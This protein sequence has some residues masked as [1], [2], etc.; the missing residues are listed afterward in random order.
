MMQEETRKVQKRFIYSIIVMCVLMG[1]H[2]RRTNVSL[3]YFQKS[4]RPKNSMGNGFAVKYNASNP[5]EFGNMELR[6]TFV[7]DSKSKKSSSRTPKVLIAQ[8]DF[9]N[10]NNSYAEIIS[11]TSKVNKAYAHKYEHDYLLARGVFI[12]VGDHPEFAKGKVAAGSTSN[13]VGI[14]EY[15]MQHPDKD[16]DYVLIMDSDA[17]MYDFER[18]IALIYNMTHESLIAHRVL[19]A[20]GIKSFNINAGVILWNI[21]HQQTQQI[22]NLWDDEIHKV[23]RKKV[24]EDQEALHKVLHRIPAKFRPVR[25]IRGDFEYSEGTVVKHFI[26]P[27]GKQVRRKWDDSKLSTSSRVMHIR[28]TAEEIC[29]KYEKDC[30]GVTAE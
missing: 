14:L 9:G 2:I 21:K 15:A 28:N 29:K 27:G 22:V 13:K 1:A 8:Y 17:M 12:E 16:W 7:D 26:R 3:E 20:T 23:F 6:R 10:F 24:G 4:F 11:I 19:E 25:A 18:D 30:N 5:D